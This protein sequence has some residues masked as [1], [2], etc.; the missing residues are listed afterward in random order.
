MS[1]FW[2]ITPCSP[3]KVSRRFRG[4]CHF[5]LQSGRISE[6]RSQ[7]VAG[8][9]HGSVCCQFLIQGSSCLLAWKLNSPK[10][11]YKVNTSK[12]KETTKVLQ[13]I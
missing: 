3:L 7:H 13:T 8:S 9:K 1:I 5:H 11:N 10:S 12:K 4:T 6:V 2:V